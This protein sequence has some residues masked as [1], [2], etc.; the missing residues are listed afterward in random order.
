LATSP[1]A[2]T[3]NCSVVK[4]LHL[5]AGDDA[6]AMSVFFL[7]AACVPLAYDFHPIIILFFCRWPISTKSQ[8]AAY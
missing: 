7:G 8:A 2:I 5:V 1:A 4:L 6:D 3:H